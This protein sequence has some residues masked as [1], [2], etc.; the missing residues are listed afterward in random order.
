MTE[1]KWMPHDYQ[2]EVVPPSRPT[3]S[4]WIIKLDDGAP[5]LA[6]GDFCG[7]DDRPGR[8]LKDG[9]I[10]QFDWVESY[11]TREL[12]FHESADG[13]TW[14]LDG[15]EPD[16][17]IGGEM[18]V[19]EVGNW[20]T[21]M[22]SLDEFASTYADSGVSDGETITITFYAWSND[23]TPFLFRGGAFHAVAEQAAA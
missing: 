2:D 8:A 17:S 3:P 9:D 11:G 22:P 10:V 18:M 5:A 16:A 23:P 15:S 12:T 6:F 19:A 4:D 14:E 7:S 20:E 21:M 1:R 13:W